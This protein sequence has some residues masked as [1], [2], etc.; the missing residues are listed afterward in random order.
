MTAR[1][2]EIPYTSF[3]DREIVLPRLGHNA[4]GTLHEALEAVAQ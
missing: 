2:R 3:R 4:W 1:L